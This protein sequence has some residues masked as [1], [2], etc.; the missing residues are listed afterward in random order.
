MRHGA[1][2]GIIQSRRR[3]PAPPLQLETALF[4]DFHHA[5]LALNEWLEATAPQPQD[6]QPELAYYCEAINPATK[7][8]AWRTAN[9]GWI[10]SVRFGE[11]MRKVAGA[12]Q[13]VVE[14]I[15]AWREKRA[16][17]WRGR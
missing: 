4:M 6:Q 5:S 10:E 9:M 15:A 2:S 3:S 7:E 12:T 8:V 1:P 11:T 14:G 16:P 17:R 13:D